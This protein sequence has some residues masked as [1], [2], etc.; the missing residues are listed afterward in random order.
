MDGCRV[1][2]PDGQVPEIG[3]SAWGGPQKKSTAVPGQEDETKDRLPPNASGRH[4]ANL[5]LS[6]DQSEYEMRRDISK[7][8]RKEVM[9]WFYENS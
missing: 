7:E 1:G 2:W 5:I 9:R 8:Q 3:T 6:P 4:P